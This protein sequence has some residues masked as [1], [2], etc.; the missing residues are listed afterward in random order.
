MTL[1]PIVLFVYNRPR[2]TAE[3]LKALAENELAADSVLYIYADG[4]KE[5]ASEET[6]KNTEE[7]RRIIR[8]KKWCKEVHIVEAVKN[9]GLATSVIEGITEIIN[10]HGKIIVLEDDLITAK[11]F[12]KFMNEGLEKYANESKVQ[13][14]SGYNFPVKDIPKNHSSFFVPMTT[15]WGWSTWKRAWEKFDENAAGYEVLKSNKE[16]EEK[17]NLD[18]SYLYSKMLL[19]Q[20]EQRSIDSWAIRFWWTVFKEKGITLFPD[21]SLVKNIGFG[22]EGTHTQDKNPFPIKDFDTD[23]FIYEFPDQVTSNEHYFE[24]IKYHIRQ[25]FMIAKPV[26]EKRKTTLVKRILNKLFNN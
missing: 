3:T 14:I 13:Q 4:V 11:G 16:L 10:R 22:N 26:E 20:M 24:N 2:H 8:E 1:A 25:I 17:F 18:N 12:L 21:R 7:T 9:K 15:S 19:K 5:N 6:K 23:Y